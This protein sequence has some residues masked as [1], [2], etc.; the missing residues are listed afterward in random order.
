[1]SAAQ[2]LSTSLLG[3]ALLPDLS[4]ASVQRGDALYQ[5]KE[6]L[7]GR[8]RG[9]EDLLPP[10]AVTCANC[11]SAKSTSRLS[12]KPAPQL[13][14]AWFSEMRQ[15]HGGPPST[16][17]QASFCKLLRTGIDPVFVLVDR[18]MPIYDLDDSQCA[19][20]WDYLNAKGDSDDNQ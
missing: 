2:F 18:E 16:Y 19:D 7:H 4:A 11:H 3:L 14:R 9:H 5:G 13:N 12:S 15:R 17:N 20:L 6:P 1:V 8:I 10:S